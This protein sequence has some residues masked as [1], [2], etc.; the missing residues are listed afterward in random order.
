MLKSRILP[1][2]G[3]FFLDKIKPTDLMNL[4]DMLEND[5]Q[6]RRISKNNGQRT[7]KPL[8]PKTIL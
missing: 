6:I 4:Y 8:S 1:Y 3:P 7:L 2:L 5:T